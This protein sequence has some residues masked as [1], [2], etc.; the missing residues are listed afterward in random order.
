MIYNRSK[1]I[2][3]FKSFVYRLAAYTAHLLGGQYG[4]AVLFEQLPLGSIF[5]CS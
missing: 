2:A 4:P 5:S 1:R 3:G